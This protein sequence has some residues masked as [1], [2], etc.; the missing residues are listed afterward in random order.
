MGLGE[1]GLGI[2]LP[3]LA[4]LRAV[5]VVGACDPDPERRVRA[6]ERWGVP[7]F[8]TTEELLSAGP[9]VVVVATPPRCMPGTSSPPWSPEPT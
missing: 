7:G 3:A 6:W 8:E 2:H 1:A 4:D 5:T 9:E